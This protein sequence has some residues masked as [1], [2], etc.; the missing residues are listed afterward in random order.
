MDSSHPIRHHRSVTTPADGA[1]APD[2]SAANNAAVK[3]GEQVMVEV[4][5]LRRASRRY[6]I[7]VL[8][9]NVGAA[10]C[11]AFAIGMLT[12]GWPPPLLGLGIVV[13]IGG[14]MLAIQGGLE[15]QKALLEIAKLLAP[16]PPEPG[17]A[18]D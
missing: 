8:F 5:A 14:V 15:R 17:A 7:G 16:D 13:M 12:D 6:W 1:N 2:G 4:V 18:V 11:T 9:I 3:R 10:L